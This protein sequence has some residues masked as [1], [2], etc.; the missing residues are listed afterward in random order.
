MQG[1]KNYFFKSDNVAVT[2]TSSET[3]TPVKTSV[4]AKKSN[5]LANRSLR[6][7]EVKML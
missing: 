2:E 7:I 4:A 3:Q 5:I 6:N 1:F